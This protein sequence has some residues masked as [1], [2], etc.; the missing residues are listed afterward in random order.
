[1]DTFLSCDWGTSTFRLRLVNTANLTVLAEEV[2]R[3]GIAVIFKCWKQENG[4]EKERLSFYRS[5][6]VTQIKKL[7]D[8][9]GRSLQHL[10][11]LIS[12][13]ASSSLGM[14]EL[15][16]KE[17]PF[18]TDG[19]D[20]LIDHIP[21]AHGFSNELFLIAGVS[22]GDDVMRGEET[23]LAGA[24]A[25]AGQ[26]AC[27][28]IFPG[29]HSKHVYVNSGQAIGFKTFMTGEFFELLTVHSILAN[30]V[31]RS[32]AAARGS[33]FQKGIQEGAASNLLNSAFHVRT[34]SLFKKNTPGENYH[35]LSGLLI[36]HE[37][38]ELEST[39]GP[40]VLVCGAQVKEQY[41]QGLSILG[42][43][44]KLSWVSAD[45]ALL[46]GQWRIIQPYIKALRL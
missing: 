18:K 35:Y 24:D 17:L 23:L 34:N 42:L 44:K 15:P 30:S 40:V 26:D 19:S 31:E 1:M 13:M 29:T 21:P 36:G 8:K 3:E 7:E 25:T 10:P 43:D 12:G 45:D 5:W 46:K 20:L 2:N 38:K 37:L 14:K 9:Q 6:L 33:Y 22:T 32:E 11:L 16:Y 4:I 28:Y 27:T 41:L 39:D